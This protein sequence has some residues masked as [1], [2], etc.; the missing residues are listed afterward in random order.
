MKITSEKKA[1]SARANGARS[2]GPVTPEGKARSSQNR[3]THGL[4]SSIVVLRNENPEGF[5]ICLRSYFDR[6]QPADEHEVDL[7]YQ[8]AA[9]AWRLRRA[10]FIETY[11]LDS[12]LD[13][14]RSSAL[15]IERTAR[16]FYNFADT[17]K[18]TSI[19]RYQ[20]RLE[21]LQSR[22]ERLQ[23]RLI[24]DFLQLRRQ[25]PPA[26]PVEEPAAEPESAPEF[27]P[28]DPPTPIHQLPNEPKTP[29]VSN[30]SVPADHMPEATVPP[31]FPECEP[32]HF[33]FDSPGGRR[34]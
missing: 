22:L 5:Q 19:E 3:T 30:Q 11:T 13:S 21:R 26:H 12:E 2:R 7:I 23:S 18:M 34:R 33:D 14:I 1:A 17:T 8:L 31:E 24:R 15:E 25:L 28:S 29:C 4:S 32:F 6:F 16:A 10:V 27:P 9:C 20:S